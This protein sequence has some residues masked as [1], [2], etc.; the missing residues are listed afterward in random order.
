MD[1]EVLKMAGGISMVIGIVL[2][3]WGGIARFSGLVDP[4]NGLYSGPITL[5]IGVVARLISH[6]KKDA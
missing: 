5:G 3:I 1:K 4:V 6:F 2:L